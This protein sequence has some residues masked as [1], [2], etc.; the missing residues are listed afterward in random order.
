MGQGQITPVVGAF[1]AT[2][3]LKCHNIGLGGDAMRLE[4]TVADER[5][6]AQILGAVSDPSA[7]VL[8]LVRIDRGS[9][10]PRLSAGKTDYTK[11]FADGQNC[12]SAFK[13]RE[14]IDRYIQQLRNEW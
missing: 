1:C 10:A 4:I 11:I 8:E 2:L 13:T 6:E 14:E 9:H 12:P 5:P 7:Y 3:N